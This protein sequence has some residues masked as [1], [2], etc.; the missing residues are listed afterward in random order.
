M[1]ANVYIED[2]EMI[3]KKNLIKCNVLVGDSKG[4]MLIAPTLSQY[5]LNIRDFSG[6]LESSS[7]YVKEG[8]EIHCRLFVKFGEILDFKS[9]NPS[10][11]F[12]LRYFYLINVKSKFKISFLSKCI[13]NIANLKNYSYNSSIFSLYMLCKMYVNTFKSFNL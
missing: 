11:M 8:I 2:K 7:F 4:I 3:L 12:F 9:Y 6:Y 10:S 1:F 5:G 13:Y